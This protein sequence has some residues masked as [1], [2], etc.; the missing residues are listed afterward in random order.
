MSAKTI[1]EIMMMRNATA[2]AR[3]P[4]SV[5][6]ARIRRSTVGLRIDLSGTA[7]RIDHGEGHPWVRGPR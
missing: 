3:H 7:H 5:R 2:M 6:R 4:K 1:V